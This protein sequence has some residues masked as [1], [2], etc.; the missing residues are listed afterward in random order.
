M[1]LQPPR[2]RTSVCLQNPVEECVVAA[3]VYDDSAVT[4][5][6]VLHPRPHLQ[7]QKMNTRPRSS[8]CLTLL[9]CESAKAVEF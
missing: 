2:M 9:V 5:V 8:T 3:S 7:R 6:P 1:L 4:L